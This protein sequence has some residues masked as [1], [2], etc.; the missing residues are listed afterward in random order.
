MSV[1]D[2]NNE[3]PSETMEPPKSALGIIKHLGPGIIIAGS[4][5]GSGELVA[6]TLAGAEAGFI[7]LW[8][9]IIGCIIKVFVQVEFG[10][11]TMIWSK[12]PMKALNDV[13]GPRIKNGANWILGF[14]LIMTC[15]V[16]VQ[17]GGILG[18]IGEACTMVQ[19]ISEQGEVYNDEMSTKINAIIK[20]AQDPSTAAVNQEAL[21]LNPDKPN[22]IKIWAIGIAVIS[23]ILLF[24]GK[25]GLIQWV[26]T[27]LVFGFT[28]ITIIN[29]AMLQTKPEWA[30]TFADLKRGLSFGLPESV[31]GVSSLGAAMAAFGIIGVGAAELIQY[32]YWCLEKGY[33]KYTGK[34]DDSEGWKSRAKGWIRILKIDAWTSMC[35]YTFSTIAFFLLGATV[36]GRIKLMPEKNNLVRTLGE[37]YVPVFGDWAQEIFVFGAFAVLYSTFFLAAAGMS[38]VV[39]DGFGL[40]GFLKN[41]EESRMK[42][43]RIIS[44]IWPLMALSLFLFMNKAPST[45]ILWSGI[46][47]AIM[48]PILGVAALYFRYKCTDVEELKPT[49][50]WDV[51]LW[52]S[53]SGMFAVGIWTAIEKFSG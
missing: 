10:R 46:T 22:D 15:L 11:H 41:D 37:M 9:I 6:T 48:L 29:L 36:L 32:P 4:I 50:L 19:P 30:I 51:F 2:K 35:V 31:N 21:N 44:G 52:I 34:R 8:L 33:S 28:I 13:P 25:F 7:L 1:E 18:A 26:S 3:P 14:W 24:Y 16:V 49:K 23:S 12:T 38:R 45:M 20:T 42:W 43:S 47:Q 40:F 53:V 39:A 17:Q 27:V 5:V